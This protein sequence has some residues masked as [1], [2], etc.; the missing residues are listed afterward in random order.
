M[1]HNG[2]CWPSLL[3]F[4]HIFPLLKVT[5]D[6][7]AS[8]VYQPSRTK[9]TLRSHRLQSLCAVLSCSVMSDSL[10]PHGQ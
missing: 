10:Q 3:N 7:V 4:G 1:G 5:L 2:P 9:K 8:H 6:A